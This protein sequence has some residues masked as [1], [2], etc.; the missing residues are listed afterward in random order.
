MNTER[1]HFSGLLLAWYAQNGRDLPWRQTRDPYRVWV[2]EIIL[3]QTRVAQGYDYFLRFVERF[4]TVEALA[5]A[6]EDEVLRLWQG[7]G[8]YS[9]ARNLHKAARQVVEMGGFPTEYE[10]IRSLKGVGDYT[11]AAIASLAFGLPYAVVD[12]NVYRVLSRYFGI[13]V[14]IDSTEGRKLFAAMAR[15]LLDARR[16]ADYNQA[17]MDFGALQCTPK[18]PDC[19]ACPLTDTCQ[20][21]AEGRVEQWPVKQHVTRVRDRYFTYVYVRC[22]GYALLQ[23]RGSGDIW[24]GLYQPPLW[25]TGRPMTLRELQEQVGTYGTLQLLRS[26]V[27]HQLTHQRLH[28]QFYLLDCLRRLPLEGVWVAEREV[29]NGYAVPRLVEEL[30]A[31]L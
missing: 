28:A 19:M 16:P 23:R 26:H 11:A 21:R 12:G 20:A 18:S 5:G 22:E 27:V 6:T 3:Q 8:Y 2:S 7:L 25:E 29:G 10:G 13:D 14:P 15:E 9:R 17:I 4:P 1:S 31:C 24:Q 30:L